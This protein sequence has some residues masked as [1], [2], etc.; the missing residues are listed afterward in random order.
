MYVSLKNEPKPSKRSAHGTSAQSI[1][2]APSITNAT[3]NPAAANATGRR[4]D[5]GSNVD[6][7]DSSHNPAKMPVADV[8]HGS[9][10][11]RATA[12]I[13]ADRVK[14][15]RSNVMDCN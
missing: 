8:D 9:D 13:S 3:G 1:P 4:S 11:T 10:T 6:T 5:E 12:R 2:A 15:M 7:K 14:R